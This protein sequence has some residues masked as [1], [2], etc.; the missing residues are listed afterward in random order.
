MTY[1]MSK[2]ALFTGLALVAISAMPAFA[3]GMN[4]KMDPKMP[5]AKMSGMTAPKAMSTGYQFEL[6][7][8]PKSTAAGKSI[9]SI[10]MMHDGKPVSGAIVIQSRADMGPSGMAGHKV[11]IKSIGEKPPGT[12]SFEI[13]NGPNG[14]MAG[15]WAVSFSAK[16]QGVAETI[17]GSVTVKLKS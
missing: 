3:D 6:A 16:V 7:A 5:D 13:D 15:N 9:V 12:Y 10:R 2:C 8:P 14:P 11:P 4:M 17:T 1:S